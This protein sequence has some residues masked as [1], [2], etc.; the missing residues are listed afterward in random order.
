MLSEAKH[1]WAR[2]RDAL[3]GTARLCLLGEETLRSA[4]GDKCGH[5]MHR[6]QPERVNREIIEFLA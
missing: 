5:F 2:D 1:L 4:Q 3:H 6:E